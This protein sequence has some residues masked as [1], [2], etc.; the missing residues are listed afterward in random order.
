MVRTMTSGPVPMQQH[1]T[2]S[3]D[4]FQRCTTRLQQEITSI[5]LDH[6]DTSYASMHISLAVFY[7]MYSSISDVVHRVLIYAF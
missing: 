2:H 4:L 1:N 5:I 3:F 6:G 7:G